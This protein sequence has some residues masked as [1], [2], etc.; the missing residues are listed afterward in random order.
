MP[1]LEAYDSVLRSALEAIINVE[2]SSEAW[3][4]SSLPVKLGGLG[5]RHAVETAVPCFISS[6]Y[7]ALPLVEQLL[8]PSISAR[9]E[10]LEEAEDT[11]GNSGARELPPVETRGIQKTWE[12]PD[13]EAAI[14]SLR[15]SAPTLQDSARLLASARPEAGAWLSCLPSPQLGTHLPDEAFRIASALRLGC[16]VCQPHQCPCGAEVT[17]KG[18]HGLACKK[19]RGR[20]SR[21][22]AA[23]D[24]IS[25][26]LRSAEVP[27]IREPPGC[28]AS[29][30]KRP[31]GL[32]LIP[33]T[34]GKSLLW[35]FTC[36]DT[37]AASY[38]S[39]TSSVAGSA[40]ALGEERK[41]KK[42]EFLLQQYLFVPVA[43]ETSGV[44]GREGLRLVRAIGQRIARVSG[45]GRAASFLL[46]RISI[47]VQRGNVAAILG[48]LPPGKEL[49]EVFLL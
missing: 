49:E 14:L 5:V 28:S 26:A 43:V 34:R 23:N 33:W 36:C 13:V 1:S 24:V 40:A 18:Y 4:Q 41:K 7:S 6:L 38:L 21:H 45:E 17:A 32:T 27:T 44:F 31:D 19:S 47:A 12:A 22:E 30:G 8:P 42:Y 11:W 25:R 35:D 9:D 15:E 29:D 20:W 39:Q 48:T 37:F 16:D 2:F 3:L 10:A 46:Q